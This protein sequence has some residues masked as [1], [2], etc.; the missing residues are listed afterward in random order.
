MTFE[1]EI[2]RDNAKGKYI[3]QIVT[4]TAVS[5]SNIIDVSEDKEQQRQP[6]HRRSAVWRN[7][8]I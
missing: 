1:N 8:R 4:T 2:L 7:C 6:L 5:A 3:E